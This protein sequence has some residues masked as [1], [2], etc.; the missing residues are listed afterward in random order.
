MRAVADTVGVEEGA[1]RALAAGAD[2]LCLGHDLADESVESVCRALTD[3][4]RDGRLPL[5]RLAEAAGRVE[6]V[7]GWAVPQ[8][9]D[10]DSA[11]GLDAARRALQVDGDVGLGAPAQVIELFPEP[12]MAAGLHE[13]SLTA[14]LGAD[15]GTTGRIVIVLRDAHRHQWERYETERLLA[16]HPDAIVVETGLPR[17]RPPA[18]RGYVATNGAGRANLEA[19]A[20]QLRRG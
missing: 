12:N 17:W 11:V 14:A 2:A 8:P 19:A 15:G 3:A 13:H 10:A 7:A 1:V 5:E 16:E 4:V 20:E 6:A 18:A 9:V